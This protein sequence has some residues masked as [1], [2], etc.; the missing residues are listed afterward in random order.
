MKYLKIK[1]NGELDI[2]LVSL[3]GGTTKANDKYKIGQ[4]GT[5]LKYVLSYLVRNNIDFKIF[6][7][8]EQ[9]NIETKTEVIREQE[10]EIIYI[11]G[12]RSSITSGMGQEWLAWM[13]IREIWCN[14]LDEGGSERGVTTET[15]GTDNSTTFYIQ[16]V[17]QIQEVID[18]WQSYFIHNL[19]P[20]YECDEF[21]IYPGGKELR[22][23]K[24]GVLI[25]ESA[26]V[27]AL[28]HYDF[29]N[30][31][32]NELRQYQGSR[33]MDIWNC[34]C[35]SPVKI[36][37]YI[38]ENCTDQHW[39][40]KEMD[41]AWSFTTL[42]DGWKEAIGNAKIIHQEALDTI[43]ARDLKIDL[44]GTLT[45]PKNLYKQLTKKFPGIGVLRVA[46]KVNEFFETYVP[47][48]E[49]KIKAALSTLETC[50]Y[51]IH[52]E[53]KFIYGA[54]GDTTTLAK[55]NLDTKEIFVS[56]KMLGKP[57][58]NVIAMLVEE[59]EHF[60]TGF[61]DCSRSFQTHFIELFTKTLLE[62]NEIPV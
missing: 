44:S 34:W 8:T 13:I 46:D 54:F 51:F 37:S 62:K 52:P 4:F 29:R 42:G 57:M 24:Q 27:H 30:A 60:K 56:E 40:G 28:F 12:E 6:V 47:K 58:F 1:N 61:Q 45:V 10:F 5:G 11:N 49:S 16:A 15:T 36:T 38:L 50:G 9:V 2:R 21:A 3:M 41:M 48:L 17:P 31:T 23:Y 35:K 20:L 55:V 43:R 33:S 22:L 26:D 7:G 25:Y 18:N 32:I 39:E 59:N 14:A 19:T 53:L